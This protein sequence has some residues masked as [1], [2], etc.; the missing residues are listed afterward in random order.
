MIFNSIRRV[1]RYNS[2]LPQRRGTRIG[3]SDSYKPPGASQ[4]LQN[5][6]HKPKTYAFGHNSAPSRN[7]DMLLWQDSAYKSPR[8][9]LTHEETVNP[10][11]NP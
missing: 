11:D 2:L 9:F 3:G 6:Q 4:T 1:F 10:V 5:P 8:F 7:S